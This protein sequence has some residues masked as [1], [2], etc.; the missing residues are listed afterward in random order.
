MVTEYKGINRKENPDWFGWVI[1]D[2]LEANP[3]ESQKHKDEIKIQLDFEVKLFNYN[4]SK[5]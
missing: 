2:L 4:K 5:H 1:L 3:N